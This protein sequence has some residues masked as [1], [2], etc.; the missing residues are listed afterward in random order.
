MIVIGIAVSA[1]LAG[2][3]AI[4]SGVAALSRWWKVRRVPFGRIGE[5]P[6]GV[7]EVH[8]RVTSKG[9]MSAPVVDR[10]CI[11]WKARFVGVP[12]DGAIGKSFD[13]RYD[14][15]D[16]IELEDETGRAVVYA[17]SIELEGGHLMVLRPSEI[18]G[19]PGAAPLVARF[20]EE[21]PPSA[22][23]GRFEIRWIE[24]DDDVWVLGR[25]DRRVDPD[26]D[27]EGGYRGLPVAIHMEPGPWGTAIV[28]A[29][30]GGALRRSL[31]AGVLARFAFG[32]S[33]LCAGVLVAA[34][35]VMTWGGCAPR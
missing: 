7:A 1:L 25:I 22:W 4:G 34:I 32:V 15:G 26:G 14:D 8:G 23:D 11:F 35:R 17:E 31:L 18:D 30:G 10:P 27:L 2:L 5:I 12:A 29:K 33:L 6:R 16:V 3:T 21:G 24:P 19:R 28:S 13:L 20:R 9:S